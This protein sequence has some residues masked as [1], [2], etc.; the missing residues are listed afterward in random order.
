MSLLKHAHQQIQTILQTGNSA[1]DATV[2]NGHDTVFLAQQVTPTGRV[3]GF[4][5]QRTAIRA[6][7]ETLQQHQLQDSVSLIQASHADMFTQIPI[8]EHGNIKA[9]M[10]NLGYLPK[11][12]K[13]IM[14]ESHSTLT[15]LNAACQL[16]APQGII[17]ILAYPGHVGGDSETVSVD[18]WCQQL[19]SAQ[20]V[21]N[22][23]LSAIPGP[24]APRLF[25]VQKR[26]RES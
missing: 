8:A 23:V 10:F 15:A 2:G 25:V 12:D 3:Y 17:T 13:S 4:D 1:I 26:P 7:L 22:V 9:I 5:I 6:T 11:G 24:A 21:V 19:D 20:F 14:T 18:N 16:L